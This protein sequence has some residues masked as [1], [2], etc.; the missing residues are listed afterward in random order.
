M[1]AVLLEAHP[2][3]QAG[4]S[5]AAR[6]ESWLGHAIEVPAAAL[7]VGEVVVLL[8]GVIMRFVFNSPIPWADELASIL[9]LWL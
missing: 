2:P 5:L 7:V 6:A 4:D 8:A 3:L 9:F 1:S